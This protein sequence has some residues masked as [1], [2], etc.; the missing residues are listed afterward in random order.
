MISWGRLCQIDFAHYL[1]SSKKCRTPT[2]SD[3]YSFLQNKPH[4]CVTCR[5]IRRTFGSGVSIA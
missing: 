2:K 4:N 5:H 3:I 1:F